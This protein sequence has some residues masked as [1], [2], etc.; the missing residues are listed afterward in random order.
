MNMRKMVCLSVLVVAASSNATEAQELWDRRDPNMIYIIRDFRARNVGDVITI[1]VEETTG[2]DAQEKRELGKN[3]TANAAVSGSGSTSSLGNALRSFAYDLGFNSSSQRTLDGKANSTIDRKFT[4]R[5]SVV[6]VGVLP[7]G[8]LVIEGCRKAMVTREMRTLRVSGIV[9]V[10]DVG[11][12][13]VVSSNFVA[14]MRIS[15]EGRGPESSYTNQ[16]WGGRVMN[17]LWPY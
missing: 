7:N 11:P 12:Y 16:G 1:L 14:N 17:K 3:T 5:L 4:D 8:D 6:V 2:F 9:R 13:N 15:Y 10:V